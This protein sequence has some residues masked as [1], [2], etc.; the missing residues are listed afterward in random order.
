LARRDRRDAVALGA[1][2]R[3]LQGRRRQP[4]E[5]VPQGE[6]EQHLLAVVRAH[7][8][9]LR[10]RLADRRD[11][12]LALAHRHGALRVR[13]LDDAFEHDEGGA[14]GAVDRKRPVGAADRRH[15]GRRPHVDAAAAAV[16]PRPDVAGLEL[17]LGP[18]VLA[19]RDRVDDEARIAADPDLGLVGEQDREVADRAGA[20][21][22]AA[23][24]VL[25]ELDRPPGLLA[26]EAQFL[27]ALG[28]DDRSG[29]RDR[30]RDGRL[31]QRRRKAQR[32][33]ASGC[34]KPQE[35][36]RHGIKLNRPPRGGTLAVVT[37]G[38]KPYQRL[39]PGLAR[40]A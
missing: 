27:A 34:E 28:G 4:R 6:V 23:D 2:R 10:R 40:T 17:E 25:P 5:G 31:R 22:V 12:A 36:Q 19:R 8:H 1:E 32:E 30:P 29:D 9:E 14:A 38:L 37:R 20:Q 24:Q 21:G 7:E 35:P 15:G 33:G 13:Q 11:G 3:A 16:R 26:H 18:A 39:P